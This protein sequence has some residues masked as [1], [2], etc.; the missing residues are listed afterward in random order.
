MNNREIVHGFDGFYGFLRDKIRA[1]R[2]FAARLLPGPRAWRG[3]TWGVILAAALV[4]T[5]MSAYAFAPAG[6][7]AFILGLLG[8][9]LAGALLGGIVIL[10]GALLR[11]V[12]RRYGWAF[13]AA[14]PLLLLTYILAISL[15]FGVIS[16]VFGLLVISSLV[17]AGLATLTG[18]GWR[19]LTRLR[20]GLALASLAVGVIGLVGGA[21]VLF[22]DGFARTPPIN[23]AAQSADNVVPLALPDPAQ[24]GP[25]T[26]RTLIYG[27]GEDRRRP[28]YGAGVDLRTTPVD[29][30]ALLE[31]WSGLRSAYWGFGPE[32]LPRNAR[33][34]YPEGDGP[35]PLVLIVH[36]NHPMEDYSDAGYAYLGELLASRGFIV[37]SVDQNFLNLSFSANLTILTSL[38][39]ENDARAWLLLEHVRQWQAW[40]ATPGTPFYGKVDFDAIALIGHSRGGEAVAL[41]AAFSQL[42]CYPDDAS[43]T[44]DYDFDI[45]TVAAIAPVDGQYKPGGQR[46]PLE[47]V[48]Y[49]VLHGAHDMDVIT[50][51]GTRQYARVRYSGDR[52]YFKAALYIYGANHGQFNSDWGRHDLF[53]PAMQLFNLRSLMPAADQEQIAK[54]ALSAFLEATLRGEDGYRALF[55]D[56]RTAA[57]WL[58]DTL[59]LS[60]YQDAETVRVATFEEDIDLSTTT[61]PGG[62]LHGANLT[63]WRE[64][65]VPLKNGSLETVAVYLG[66]DNTSSEGVPVP[67]AGVARYSIT[68]PEIAAALDPKS[69]FS[70][71]LADAD[72]SPHLN[73]QKPSPA[74]RTPIDLMLEL[75]DGAGNTAWLPL[76]HFALLQPQIRGRIGKADFMSVVPLSEPVFQ[77]FSFRL[78]DFAAA[79]PHFDPAT[80]AEITFVFDRTPAGVV[81]LDE[82]G[83]NP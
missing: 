39:E 51:M 60:Q 70:F 32:A 21:V 38:K 48:N 18:G 80:L 55:R 45:R 5:V 6:P 54:V 69:V 79:N 29:G 7:V 59:Y 30:A 4:W 31:G 76:S 33:V 28:E 82:I 83:L 40:D 65:V 67:S 50:F 19:R 1:A 46:L 20:R 8:G 73:T 71:S 14:L 52:P 3:A 42:P 57:T 25:Y 2:R 16:L 41:A 24:P 47:D 58:P 53:G 72:E 11:L 49:L 23:A 34:W 78:A 81:I 44:F 56:P 26:V 12:P 75:R 17:G 74:D 36:G 66:W 35:F 62:T 63:I 9:L 77:T 27:S 61:L 43:V 13:I 10:L 68:L 64:Q 22:M 37:A 15:A